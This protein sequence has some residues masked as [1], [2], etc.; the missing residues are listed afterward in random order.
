MTFLLL[1]L[2][3]AVLVEEVALSALEGHSVFRVVPQLGEVL[4]DALALGAR[5]DERRADGVLLLDER[6][7]LLGVGILHP[8]VGVGDLDGGGTIN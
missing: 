4:L 8:A 7:G 5:L 1:V 3:A 2:Q 6:L